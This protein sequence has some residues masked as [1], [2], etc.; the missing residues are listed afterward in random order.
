MANGCNAPSSATAIDKVTP[1][2]DINPATDAA[3]AGINADARSSGAV[4]TKS[5]S[6]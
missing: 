6:A 3:V 4:I 1:P 2:V 5:L